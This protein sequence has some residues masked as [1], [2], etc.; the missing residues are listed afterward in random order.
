[1]K[2]DKTLTL[3]YTAMLTAIVCIATMF[4]RVPTVIGYDG[5]G[6]MLLQYDIDEGSYSHFG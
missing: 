1:M 5:E 3:T 2:H 6:N 4:F